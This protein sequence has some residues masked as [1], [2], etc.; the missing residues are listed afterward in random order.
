MLLLCCPDEV[1][2]RLSWVL[3]VVRGRD[4]SPT[5]HGHQLGA[6]F[7]YPHRYVSDERMDQISGSFSCGPVNRILVDAEVLLESMG[8]IWLST[9]HPT[10]IAGV[11]HLENPGC[12]FQAFSLKWFV[13]PSNSL[14]WSYGLFLS[15]YQFE[16][17]SG[18]RMGHVSSFFN[19]RTPSG[20]N[21]WKPCAC[22]LGFCEYKCTLI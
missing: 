21:P 7:S 17:D 22:C 6:T 1:Q 18:V 9:T 12:F 15:G 20:N 3:Q 10:C 13:S 8:C 11:L 5:G 16:I 2:W 19:S 4:S 14:G